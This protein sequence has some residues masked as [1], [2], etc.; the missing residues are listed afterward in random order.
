MNIDDIPAGFELVEEETYTPIPKGF[1]LVGEEEEKEKEDNSL[2]KI[3]ATTPK[4]DANVGLKGGALNTG[5]TGLVSEK[6]EEEQTPAG[7]VIAE[8][9]TIDDNSA[10]EVIPDTPAVDP[11]T[12][13][14]LK[15]D[16]KEKYGVNF[17]NITKQID[18]EVSSID[19]WFNEELAK[20]FVDEGG[21]DTLKQ[22]D[23]DGGEY[24]SMNA[25]QQ[26]KYNN[27]V[28]EYK[29]KLDKVKE[30]Y[31]DVN[32]R[33]D[34]YN[35][36][37]EEENKKAYAE[38][39][40]KYLE[41][42]K[43]RLDL[44]NNLYFQYNGDGVVQNIYDESMIEDMW[45]NRKPITLEQFKDLP[46]NKN[47]SNMEAKR[48]YNQGIWGKP[49]YESV[50]EYISAWNEDK[51]N[52]Y[53]QKNDKHTLLEEFEVVHETDKSYEKPENRT[54]YFNNVIYSDLFRNLGEGQ[55]VPALQELLPEGFT[56]EE[57][58]YFGFDEAKVLYGDDE[59]TIKVDYTTDTD[60]AVINAQKKILVDF[61]T[62][63]SN[64]LT[65]TAVEDR[66]KSI[67]EYAL[68]IEQR[69]SN[70]PT[71][72][73]I[74][75]EWMRPGII[76][77]YA[78][79]YDEKSGEYKVDM[80]KFAKVITPEYKKSAEGL[81]ISRSLLKKDREEVD[82]TREREAQQTAFNLFIQTQRD[83]EGRQLGISGEV[84]YSTMPTYTRDVAW[85]DWLGNPTDGPDSIRYSTGDLLNTYT[86]ERG[87]GS[88]NGKLTSLDGYEEA[89]EWSRENSEA[90]FFY[91]DKDGKNQIF[92]T[93]KWRE[94]N[95]GQ[96]FTEYI[97]KKA[98]EEVL[99]PETMG[100][101]KKRAFE[102]FVEIG[103]WESE[104]RKI[105]G[106]FIL[107]ALNIDKK[108]T[109]ALY[110]NK[111]QQ[112][113]LQ[114][115]YNKI[116]DA[117]YTS[118]YSQIMN[119]PGVE[120]DIQPGDELV[121]VKTNYGTKV[122][123]PKRITDRAGE[124]LVEFTV[125]SEKINKN[126]VDFD[127][128]SD[129][130]EDANDRWEVYKLN[131]SDLES[132]SQ[133]FAFSV[134]NVVT[135]IAY[136]GYKYLTPQ[137]WVMSAL[138]MSGQINED[139]ITEAMMGWKSWQEKK[140]APY[141]GATR[142]GEFTNAYEFGSWFFHMG[143]TQLPQFG[144]MLF[145]GGSAAVPMVAMG[146]MA[147][148]S[149][150]LDF[151]KQVVLGKRDYN[152][153]GI[154]WRSVLSGTSESVFASLPTWKILNKGKSL[155]KGT[156]GN[157][158]SRFMDGG[159]DYARHMTPEVIKD[160]GVD[161]GFEAVN[162]IVQNKLNGRATT[163]G[164]GEIVATSILSS[165]PVAVVSPVYY[166][167]TTKDFIGADLRENISDL[168][169]KKSRLEQAN[170]MLNVQVTNILGKNIGEGFDI[171]VADKVQ[172]L[173]QK[174]SENN[175][176][177]ENIDI[178][179]N[180]NYS[181]L[182]NR[183][184]NKGVNPDGSS[185][186][187]SIISYMGILKGKAKEILSNKELSDTERTKKLDDINKL[188]LNLD[189]AKNFYT[190]KKYFGNAFFALKGASWFNP[191]KKTLYKKL[192]NDA[193]I[194]LL[195][196]NGLDSNPTAEQVQDKAID[197]YSDQLTEKQLAK[198]LL[199]NPDLKIARSIDEAK[200]MIENSI[201]ND[202]QKKNAIKSLEKGNRNG[203]YIETKGGKKE[204]M[205]FK[206]NMVTNMKFNTGGHETS[207]GPSSKLL[208]K[209]PQAFT[210]FGE[211]I[212]TYMENLDPKLWKA[213][214]VGNA[215]IIKKDEDGNP[216][217]E[218]DYEEVVA[219]FVE[220]VGSGKILLD[221]KGN[222]P[223]L[224]G[225][226]FNKGLDKASNGD[227]TIPF[228]GQNDIVEWFHGLATAL[229]NGDITI[230]K[231][232]KLLTEAIG[233]DLTTDNVI[234]LKADQT[235]DQKMAASTQ[236]A[237]EQK[238]DL[239]PINAL[240]PNT[241]KTKD[242][243]YNP[244]VFNPI[245]DSLNNKDGAINTYITKRTAGNPTLRTK[246][247]ENVQ[248]RLINF[249][250][251]SKR[252]DGS[253]VGSEGF[254]EF[255][256]ANV[257][258]GKMDAKKDLAIESEKKKRT[259]SIDSA[260]AKQQE[261]P[262]PST[263]T[264]P[265]SKKDRVTPR[266]KL[267]KAAPEFV[268]PELQSEVETAVLEILEGVTPD[269]DSK[270]FKPFIKEVLE[271]KLTGPVKKALGLGK[272]YDF[273]IK[274]LGPKLKDILPVDYFVKIESQ[275]KPED[276]IFT[277]P[278]VRLTKQADI[279]AAMLD[280]KVY[281][282][283]TKQGVN[284][285]EFKDFDSKKLIDYILAPAISPTTGKKSGLKGNRKTT[286]ATTIAS[287]LGKD[288]LPSIMKEL[289][290]SD[291][292]IATA[293]RKIQRDPRIK[294]SEGERKKH[295]NI[296]QESNGQLP[297]FD[298]TNSKEAI[299]SVNKVRDF[300]I[301]VLAPIMGGDVFTLINSSNL[302]PIGN[303]WFKNINQGLFMGDVAPMSKKNAAL[304]NETV[305]INEALV[306][307]GV[308]G[309]LKELQQD[310]EQALGINKKE[311][312][313]IISKVLAKQELGQLEDNLEN[314]SEYQNAVQKVTKAFK[315]AYDA[316][317]AALPVIKEFLYN[318]NA[319]RMWGK[320]AALVRSAIDGIV[321][322]DKKY[323]EH[324]YQFG[325]WSL[326]TIQA[327]KSKNPKVYEGWL[328]WSKDN[329]Y[330]TVFDKTTK[331]MGS[332]YQTKVQKKGTVLIPVDPT[333]MTY[334]EIVDKKY[335]KDGVIWEA[336]AGEHPLLEERMNEAMKTGD[337]SK[338][339]PAEIRFF[340]EYFTLNPFTLSLD[341]QSFA[342]KYGLKVDPKLESNPDIAKIAG[343][344]IYQQ[345]LTQ[346]GVL[347]GDNVMTPAK[348]Q[349]LLDEAIPVLTAEAKVKN[350]DNVPLLDSA[351]VL[352]MKNSDSMTS[353]DVINKARVIDEALRRAR[354]PNAPIKKIR[355]FD[356]D[357]T[358]ARTNSKVLYE[359][360]D[361]RT[362]T[363]T[364]EE[365]AKKGD[366]MLAEGAVWDF[367]EFNKVV[368]GKKGP[369][370][371]IAQKIQEVR[372]TKDVFVLTARAQQASPAIKEFLDSIGLNIP[373]DNI[374]GLGDSS[375]YAKSNWIVDKAAQGYNDFYFAD[376]HT[377]NVKAVR[378]ALEVLDVKSKT[379]QAKIKF[380]ENL[381][382]EFNIILEESSGIDRFKTYS[383]VK[384]KVTGARKGKYKLL[385]PP[386]AE[387]FQ[388]L[389]YATLGKGKQGM[390]H[391]QFYDK[392]LLKP[393]AQAMS[394]L[395]TDRVNL[396]EDF[397]ALK[398]ELNVPKDLRK[399]TKSGFTNEQAVRVYLWTQTGETIPGISKRDLKELNDII[400][401]DPKL[402][403]FADQMLSIT[404]GDG[405]SK[406]TQG[407]ATGTITTD[408]IDLLNTTKRSKY[409]KTWQENIDIIF[410]KENLNKLEAIH[411]PKYVEALHNSLARMKSGKNR[412]EGGNRL[413]N[414]VLD[415][416][417]NSTA[418]TMFFNTRSALLQTISA[419]NFINWGFNSPYHAGKAFANQPQY[420]KDFTMLM[421]SD[422]LVDRRNGLKLN[423]NESEIAD[424]AKTSK[425]K[426]KAV[427]NYI[428]EKGFLP[429]KYADSFAIASG[430]ALF[431]RNR[432]NDL[433]KNEGK[434]KAEAEAQALVEFK[435]KSEE[436][437]QSSDPSKISQQQ[438]SDL[439][440]I[441]LQYVNTPMQY[442]RIQKRDIQ[443]IIN[444]R[445][446]PG[447]TLAQSNRTRV[448]RI[449]YY[450]FVQ[451]LVFNALQ[452]ALYAVGFGDNED[453]LTEDQLKAI[454]SDKNE[455]YFNT[456]N[457]MLDSQ[458][459]GLGMGGVT[460]SV[461]KNLG[462]NIYD[463]SKKDRPEYSDAWIKLLEFSPAIKSKLSKLRSAGYPFDSKK[464][465][466]EVFDKGFSLDNP[467]YE[468]ASKVITAVTNV[469]LDR[470]FSKVN[471]L[472]DAMD[473]DTEAWQ[474]V[475]IILGWPKW[476]LEVDMP[477]KPLSK[478]EKA[479]VKIDN[480]KANYKAAK[481]S[482]DY[483]TIK[484]L[485]ASQQIKMLKGLGY[486]DY[487]IKNAKSEKQKIDL[488]IYKNSGGKIKVDKK[489]E[490]T[491]KYKALSKG[492]QIA[493][494]DSLG[495]SKKDISALKYEEDRVEKL[496]ELMK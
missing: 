494:L 410:S 45:V 371:K 483:D 258:F 296:R 80:F 222:I 307:E 486:G 329:Y 101:E 451:N 84:E 204:Y 343:D 281:V 250:P 148:G 72:P 406:P 92:D 85:K 126:L 295:D 161:A 378:D 23:D 316:N 341:G 176:S 18:G 136:G 368:D 280:D 1:E 185:D 121:E 283:N 146:A 117:P 407:W 492:E 489:A 476:Q 25:D 131:Y 322:G 356:F 282:E 211:Q 186:F 427:L 414:R 294:M 7:D 392:A 50:D 122:V 235:V 306:A 415:Y 173:N 446:M 435:E 268:T 495:L 443:D 199:A 93:K 22:V 164:L 230:G 105:Q 289:G 463:R 197:L 487:T 265:E 260:E 325:N 426:A 143:G 46:E 482:V 127:E 262:S 97:N 140:N 485:N 488:I 453:D 90:M 114:S 380:S 64:A 137:G 314:L 13:K 448:A 328:K 65:I 128:L 61:L 471:N 290:M 162:G 165:G 78:T 237:S 208:K 447:K 74:N 475:A 254:G 459:R 225:Y 412:I 363:L 413:S 149:S 189:Q 439:G 239:Q 187:N 330:Q 28:T 66:M 466:Q 12:T 331:M 277:K 293:S 110:A 474:S 248:N 257:N 3:P 135:D 166:A 150:D 43:H 366:E 172:E 285:Y 37:A 60:P 26:S 317:P 428:L 309:T 113:V 247:M 461:I 326:R 362:G 480:A 274:K 251:Q 304:Y 218:W 181:E 429:T 51:R 284:L 160:V 40:K 49:T 205:A 450:A 147:A 89:M 182:D 434:T 393:Y 318:P 144:V 269:A 253:T 106:K 353:Q 206:P 157:A 477:D 202:E 71:A 196:T 17:K 369:L 36:L 472:K 180:S 79:E 241:V 115:N 152:E 155:I 286:T 376:D 252:K 39:N 249:D 261:A 441:I 24:Y 154:L 244:R 478:E 323:E 82:V 370:F 382:N 200:V 29:T 468:S 236:K 124:E 194:S 400:E 308:L 333:M 271:G 346:A 404:K 259:E 394:N 96:N 243:Y 19:A 190:S 88:K 336:Q 310:V 73:G 8:D 493:K 195:E 9:I 279:D 178:D 275:T 496:L 87:E 134:A 421:N 300:V 402:K 158:M 264:K 107:S 470:I 203:M 246:I 231:Y 340:N 175:S 445:P 38:I 6:I 381:S 151:R 430:G 201:M 139:P 75:V 184:K 2:E 76:K 95:G 15:K 47:M 52:G 217:N 83:E 417:N 255:I 419:A 31:K 183:F 339:P 227:Y 99:V 462:I 59:V 344:L 34:A 108:T 385:I 436:A 54:K 214:Q 416:I 458:L 405:Y 256:F 10:P 245:F 223:A 4:K 292:E 42:K 266:S 100:N 104:E 118:L 215:N 320:N 69:P 305:A 337:F 397:K 133:N 457:G 395:S 41:E 347:T 418:V 109:K 98:I 193:K 21:I 345:I 375:P 409:L 14:S 454:S 377:S 311:G 420:W 390:K 276:R 238:G 479:V 379:Q 352:N 94:E 188:Y 129:S 433:I 191:K 11:P 138:K 423:I 373:L 431:Y 438:S 213:I 270:D 312:K 35:A 120:I 374:S 63:H 408:L 220:G 452:Q 301:D 469:P 30:D 20:A 219:S 198:D 55:V 384:A 449:A 484:K 278:P 432:V 44:T 403:V 212:V 263:T 348:A 272:N 473:E 358:L 111:H 16:F 398:K 321:K 440:R 119:L 33:I 351:R 359:M 424:A 167:M 53:F 387:D 349:E 67:N 207:H 490:D 388:G 81:Q 391:L 27:L 153:F 456:V 68:A 288:M 364:A 56:V 226:L 411:G 48:K 267:K 354:D 401:K 224:L 179:L 168:S 303:R 367:S 324:T 422:Y 297:Y 389:L 86:M 102:N 465:R 141:A 177:I 58:G 242:E 163:E 365:F 103:N 442:S 145:S 174:I 32:E 210:D 313:T 357:D 132:N 437:Q 464:R 130:I 425:N 332:P 355:V 216:T 360:P 491:A 156:G 386:S 171:D 287:E 315:K 361:G 112:R 291:K 233:T 372:G 342:A 62:K 169:Y 159:W 5:D 170:S 399:Q 77:E 327:I 298:G 229:N 302:S 444:R 57:A 70:D 467:A 221:K 350:S 455:R 240:L 234:D 334:Q 319:S 228:N 209:N 116:V 460:L 335:V 192:M 338:V 396:M 232:E 91:I 125:L 123:V 383:D 299:K 273:L 481:G 142:F